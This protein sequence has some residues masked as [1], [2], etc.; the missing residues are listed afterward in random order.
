MLQILI[1]TKD[2]PESFKRAI[3]SIP[4]NI[5]YLILDNNKEQTYTKEYKNTIHAPEASINEV[6]QIL[7][8]NAQEPFVY[9]LED[10]DKFLPC[11]Q[12]ILSNLRA[13]K[14]S[15]LFDSFDL[16]LDSK[17]R[18]FSD[19]CKPGIN[20]ITHVNHFNI[21]NFIFELD[22]IKDLDFDIPFHIDNDLY[23]FY[24]QILKDPE[25]F[26]NPAKCVLVNGQ[27]NLTSQEKL[28]EPQ[29]PQFFEI[30]LKNFP[31][32]RHEIA[33]F[34]RHFHLWK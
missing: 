31:D 19:V 22:K 20:E 8:N 7:I 33:V 2:R 5:P 15:V 26:Y 17:I 11:F 16:N 14:M 10:D 28:K 4:K 3:K 27:N 18:S 24:W 13:H 6:Y 32:K 9:F 34:R 30:L 21:P 1:P 12:R 25:I 23:L 29:E